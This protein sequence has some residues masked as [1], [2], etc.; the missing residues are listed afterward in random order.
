MTALITG[1]S[2]GIGKELAAQFAKDKI[3]L[4]LV[5]RRE[6]KL[7]RL[8]K[9][10][11]DSC[12][13]NVTVIAIDLSQPNSANELFKKVQSLRIEVRYLVNNAGFGD[14][15]EFADSDIRKQEDMIN[16][17][18]LTLTKLTR[19]YAG[20]MKS[21]KSGT[22]LNIASDASFRPGPMMS[23]YFATKHYVLAF[24]EAIAE[25]LK[26]Y[27][28]IVSALCPGATQSEFGEVAGF[29]P[30]MENSPFPTSKEVAEYG[31]Q[32]MKNGKI[33]AVHGVENQKR[34]EQ[35]KTMTR[36]EVREIAYKQMKGFASS[37]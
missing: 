14:L 13:I 26:P 37:T 23:V 1:A 35:E 2:A 20:E 6:E 27:G 16:L 28:V 30:P 32:Q 8:A 11:S 36:K 7:K 21:R 12:D 17:N 25:E 34:I 15:G 9:Q 31:Y 19:L 10:L 22:I 18:V 24:S 3:D 29:G 33:V 4:I 5:A